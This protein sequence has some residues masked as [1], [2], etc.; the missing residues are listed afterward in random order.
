MS[1]T[2]ELKSRI[3]ETN[4]RIFNQG[5]LDYIDEA[6]AEDMV[7]HNVAHGEDYEGREA[8]KGW[9]ESFREAYPDFEAEILDT[10][11]EGDT[12][13]TRYRATGTHEGPL[14]PFN[15]EPTHKE[16]EFEGV[17][18]HKMD[19]TKATEA[20]WFYD[21]LTTLTQLGLVPEAPP[22]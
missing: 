5:D 8:F 7:M 18:I 1:A 15:V 21:Q 19:G 10:V 14:P 20:W 13:V 2:E 9:V 16:I 12:V 17:T 22:T 3:E 4:D 11:V 6:Y